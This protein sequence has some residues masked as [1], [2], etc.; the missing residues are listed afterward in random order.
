MKPG[1]A[2]ATARLIALATAMRGGDAPAGAAPW[3]ARMLSAQRTDRLLLRSVRNP[4]G[5]G[6]WNAVERFTLP[7][8][9]AH[10]L[11][12]KR[13]ID[14]LARAAAADG[15]T[16]LLVLG[17]GLDTLAWRLAEGRVFERVVSADHP[18][19]LAAVE[20][21]IAPPRP[22]TLAPTDL[23]DGLSQEVVAALD[24]R[25]PTLVVVE[26]VLMYLSEQHAERVLAGIASLP[27]P[28]VRLVASFMVLRPNEPIG[29]TNQSAPVRPWL[30]SRGEPMRWATTDE[31]LDATLGRLGWPTRA[32]IGLDA[33]DGP[34]PP[35]LPDERLVVADR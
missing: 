20:R 35:G 18:A 19:T 24:P 5:R 22:V 4:I 10:W 28:R 6:F 12:R 23:A 32:F 1:R 27:V 3:C 26:G 31:L 25:A 30:A 14:R 15:S 2:S 21:A 13:E 9:V 33:A 8:M 16:Q 11:R 7:G 34:S 29:F 17:A